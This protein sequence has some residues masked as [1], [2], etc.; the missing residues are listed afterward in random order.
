M[1]STLSK[2]NFNFSVTF[3]L[4]SANAF[5]LDHP[6]I[7]SFGKGLTHYQ[8]TN[9]SSK[10]KGFA[11]DNFKFDENGRKLSKPVEN[12]VGKGEIARYEQFLLFPHCFQQACFPGV[13]KGVIV[14]QWVKIMIYVLDSKKNCWKRR[15]CS[16]PAIVLTVRV[17]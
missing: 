2:S 10:L 12:S 8:M 15:K 14:W 13:S 9:Y 1:F 17:V 5:T 3:I 4:L 16:S 6:K 7:L 11:D